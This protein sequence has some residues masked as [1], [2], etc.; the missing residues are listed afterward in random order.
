MRSIIIGIVIGCV[1]G[2]M[3]GATVVAPRLENADSHLSGTKKA[4]I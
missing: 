2:V 3:F 4:D 1:I